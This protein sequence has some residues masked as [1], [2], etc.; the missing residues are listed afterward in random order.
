M[1][2]DIVKVFSLLL[3]LGSSSCTS[4]RK[5]PYFQ[6]EGEPKVFEM[7]SN[8]E[9]GVIRFQPEDIIAISVNVVGEQ[10]IVSDYSLLTSAADAGA[11]GGGGGG[12]TY[13]VSSAGEINFPTLGLI[14]V[15]G[16]SPE[17]LR[18]H[19]KQ[20]L[21][22]RMKV[23]PIVNVRLANFR[24]Y[25]LGDAGAHQLVINKDRIDIFEAL[26]TGGDLSL[27]GRRDNVLIRRKLPDG[28]FKFIRIDI[29]K[30]DISTSPY[31]Y[32]RQNDLI[33][34]QPGRAALMQPDL[35][36]MGTITS[37]TSFILGIIAIVTMFT[38]K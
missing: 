5:I 32:L 11:E 17:E 21:Q 4:Y 35:A 33:Y 15:A 29:S 28:N 19:I 18:E 34:V 26:A 14:K 16:F 38:R 10:Q 3:L 31:F 8:A 1:K 30:A 7:K 20:L 36:M 12:Q 24:I 37:I 2:L 22:E 13:L 27:S 23:E 9:K 25:F 6:V